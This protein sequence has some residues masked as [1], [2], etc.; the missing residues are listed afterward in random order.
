M[1][2]QK[3]FDNKRKVPGDSKK[4]TRHTKKTL[5]NSVTN[6]VKLLRECKKLAAA[7]QTVASHTPLTSYFTSPT[8]CKM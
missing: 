5:T 6:I 7:E 1:Y 3:K 8:G 4:T 2:K